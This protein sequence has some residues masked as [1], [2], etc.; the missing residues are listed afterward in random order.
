MTIAELPLLQKNEVGAYANIV[1]G[2]TCVQTYTET[3]KITNNLRAT[4]EATIQCGSSDRFEVIP[5]KI[6]L[7]S[8][9]S[10][11]VQV[12][13]KV[14]KYVQKKKAAEQGQRDVFRIKVPD[15]SYVPT[16]L[17]ASHII[18]KHILLVKNPTYF[19]FLSSHLAL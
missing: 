12:K 5:S 17:L 2:F 10:C 18:I 6:F 13:L 19:S 4:V 15:L 3:L 7:K 16:W 1:D 8:G 11:Q 9:H 14:L